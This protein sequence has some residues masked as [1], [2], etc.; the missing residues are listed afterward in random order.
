MALPSPVITRIR[1]LPRGIEFL[2]R[3]NCS[4]LLQSCFYTP[5]FAFSTPGVFKK[6]FLGITEN[7]HQNPK[8]KAFN[9]IF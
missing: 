1:F 7:V 6:S 2:E 3:L 8:K 4:F 9:V 5:G